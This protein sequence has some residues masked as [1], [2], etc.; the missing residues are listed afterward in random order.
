MTKEQYMQK[1]LN[2]FVEKEYP[3]QSFGGAFA[4]EIR[5]AFEEGFKCAEK[6][7]TQIK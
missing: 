3:T 4:F 2:N 5:I 7:F 1:C 6:Y